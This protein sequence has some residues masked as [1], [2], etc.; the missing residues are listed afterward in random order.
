MTNGV[1]GV[2][3]APF[4]II[5]LFISRFLDLWDSLFYCR[6]MRRFLGGFFSILL[7]FAGLGSVPRCY[8]MRPDCANRGTIQCPLAHPRT[9]TAEKGCTACPRMV[10][11]TTPQR[12][13][14]PVNRLAR[15]S[16]DQERHSPELSPDR[17][18]IA[19]IVQNSQPSL[20]HPLYDRDGFSSQLR[21]IPEPPLLILLQKQSFLI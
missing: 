17:V 18:P 16:I 7:I 12:T 21:S 2:I 20:A 10:Q 19:A 5:Q 11:K 8:V 9:V 3:N 1:Y 15:F 14:P 6:F 13:I 4:A